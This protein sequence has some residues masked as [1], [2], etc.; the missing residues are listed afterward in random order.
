MKTDTSKKEKAVNPIKSMKGAI[1]RS[2]LKQKA[3]AN[4]STKPSNHAELMA[5]IKGIS[6]APAASGLNA[7]ASA[8]VDIAHQILDKSA[9]VSADGIISEIVAKKG[10]KGISASG[11]LD[12]DED[13]DALLAI[14]SE[15][16][17]NKHH[18]KGVV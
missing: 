15:H 17:K 5:A 3:D 2:V 14:K 4:P 1:K 18:K 13:D 7:A 8:G 10:V 6:A 11:M 16:S 12:D 9:G